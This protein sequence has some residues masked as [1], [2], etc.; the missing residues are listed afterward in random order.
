[1]KWINYKKRIFRRIGKSLGKIGFFAVMIC[2]AFYGMS[3][4]SGTSSYYNDTENSNANTFSAGTLDF[5]LSSVGD[6][7]PTTLNKSE[8]AVRTINLNQNGSLGFQYSARVSALS[9]DICNYLDLT[10]TLDGVGVYSGLLKNFVYGSTT[11]SA[12]EQWIFTAK[13]QAGAPDSIQGTTCNFDFVFNGTQI[14][15]VGFSDQETI[16]NN[17]A[18]KYWNPPVVLNEFLPNAGEYPEFIEIYNKT[19]FA[20]DLSGFYVMA[21]SN[22]ILINSTTTATYS[23]SSTIIPANGWLVVTT[24]DNLMNDTAGTI[25]LYNSHDIVVDAHT[26]GTATDVNVN[27]TPDQTNNLVAYLPFDV[28]GSDKSGNGNNGTINGATSVGG[29]INQGLSFNGTSN[30][31]SVN[32]S[33]SLDIS[34]QI[35]VEEW[36]KPFTT[37]DSTNSNMRIMDK[38]NA[39][40]LLFDYPGADGRL[41]FILRIGGNYVDLSSTTNSWT[42]DKWYHI[43]GTYDG[44]DMKIYVNGTLENS[45]SITGNIETSSYKLFFGVRAVNNVPTNMFFNGVIDEVKIYNQA[46]STSEVVS[47]YGQVPADK[48]YARIPDGSSNWVDPFPTPG[49]SNILE[50]PVIE[51][52]TTDDIMN[53]DNTSLNA[54]ISGPDEQIATEAMSVEEVQQTEEM[55]QEATTSEQT[56][57]LIIDQTT[58]NN[59]DDTIMVQEATT[60]EQIQEPIIE[61]TTTDN[62]TIEPEPVVE[63]DPVIAPDNNT[64]GGQDSNT[65]NN[66]NSDNNG[67][68][69]NES[70]PSESTPSE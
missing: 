4:L 36:I 50:E 15:G 28:D 32:D 21:N 5:S 68:S 49:K 58:T 37:I 42:A 39:Y 12:P 23:G 26:Y 33:S 46:L 18:A 60:S 30:Y 55:A 27:N 17:V 69:S 41:K 8:S 16:N 48:S 65:D 44:S 61:Q 70:T 22:K 66:S 35:T 38:Q 3:I 47:H 31:V 6:F 59:T 14:G 43:V 24:G 25:T 7:S 2:F 1:M 64:S 34:N 56:Q 52:T 40:Y 53:T 20:I 13:L 51:Q 9:G 57:A 63:T 62:T 54:F 45:K 10:A 67:S 29:R 11:F 19:G